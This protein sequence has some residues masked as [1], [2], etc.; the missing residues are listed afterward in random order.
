MLNCFSSS[1]LADSLLLSPCLSLFDPYSLSSLSLVPLSD[2][3][4]FLRLLLGVCICISPELLN[5]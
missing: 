3:T 5:E 2:A 4:D 1:N